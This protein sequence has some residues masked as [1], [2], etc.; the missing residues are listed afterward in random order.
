M[1]SAEERLHTKCCCPKDVGAGKFQC[2]DDMKA[3]CGERMKACKWI[4]LFS[5]VLG[6]SALL[7]GYFLNPESVRALWLVI[8]GGV[9][10]VGILG[11]VLMRSIQKL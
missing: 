6:A 4:P 5:V 7:L 10:L 3:R 9:V 2:M 8:S 1:E 11:L